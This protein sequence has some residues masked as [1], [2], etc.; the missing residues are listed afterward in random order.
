[1]LGRHTSLRNQA[2]IV[3]LGTFF[4]SST[5][6]PTFAALT[7]G[8]S[9]YM[10]QTDGG[11][12]FVSNE[13]QDESFLYQSGT[14]T[15]GSDG[16][17]SSPLA[18]VVDGASLSRSKITEYQVQSGDTVGSI[19]EKFKISAD[20][21]TVNNGIK[22]DKIK[23]GQTLEIINTDG[24]IYDIDKDMS[25]DAIAKEYK[26]DIA[27]LATANDLTVEAELKRGEVLVIPGSDQVAHL[28][29]QIEEAAKPVI[30][31]KKAEPAA[32][33]YKKIATKEVAKAK[34]NTSSA[35]A[36]KKTE[37]T[38]LETKKGSTLVWPTVGTQQLSQ[39]YKYGHAAL[40]IITT[41]GD[42]TTAI[43]AASGGKVIKA[44]G[45]W[46]GGYGNMIVI[47]HGNGMKTLYAHMRELYVSPGD[48]VSAG[49]KI[50]W[51]GN[52]GNVRG[53]T[54][55]HLHFEVIVNSK[56]VNP[57]SYL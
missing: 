11:D 34:T 18:N 48:T 32:Q 4:V 25:L 30:V 49:Q 5:L 33:P 20:T 23:P 54:G 7:T 47:D 26:V 38:V 51:M 45:G 13:V 14:E 19:A 3:T 21:L 2:L 22:E 28:K 37:T 15:F 52:T 17:I 46:N 57:L 41:K 16:V 1:M 36:F 43:V 29:K 24:I 56:L 44:Q 55:L 12:F 27:T 8:E 31:E 53:P 42:R 10:D 40:D 50:G 39:G 6:L 35:S 9:P